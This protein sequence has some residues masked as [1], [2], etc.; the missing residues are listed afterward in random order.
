[1]QHEQIIALWPKNDALAAA[2]GVSVGHAQVIRHRG[3]IPP[4]YWSNVVAAAK[5]IGENDVDHDALVSGY[6]PANPAEAA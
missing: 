1:M 3:R 5:E 2:L 6:S 4:R